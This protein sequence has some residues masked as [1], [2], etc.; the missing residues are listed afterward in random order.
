MTRRSLRLRLFLVGALAIVAALIFA[1]GGL[2]LLF[3]HHVERTLDDDLDAYVRQIASQLENDAEIGR[4]RITQ[5]ASDPR[6]EMPL[7]RFYWQVSDT[8]ASDIIRSRSLGDAALEPRGDCVTDGRTHYY[9][10]AGPAHQTL[11]VGETCIRWTDRVARCW[12]GFSPE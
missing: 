6:F 9:R 2:V 3:E 4:L 5:F 7:S 12:F 10:I 1:A 11:L 8:G